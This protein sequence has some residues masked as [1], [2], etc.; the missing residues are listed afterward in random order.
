MGT[1]LNTLGDALKSP[2][3]SLPP[4][5]VYKVH[6]GTS[7]LELTVQSNQGPCDDTDVHLGL[8]E[9]LSPQDRGP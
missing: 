5:P 3:L 6:E 1:A 4:L 7:F 9:G 8:H 2:A